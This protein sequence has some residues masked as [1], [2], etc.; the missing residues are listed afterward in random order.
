[1]FLPVSMS[2]KM[3]LVA[4]TSVSPFILRARDKREES[5]RSIARERGLKNRALHSFESRLK[6][7]TWDSSLIRLQSRQ[8]YGTTLSPLSRLPTFTNVTSFRKERERERE[9]MIPFI[10]D[11]HRWRA[12]REKS[13]LFIRFLQLV[14]CRFRL[15]LVNLFA[16]CVVLFA[17]SR[18]RSVCS[19][20]FLLH[21]IF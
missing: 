6:K 2:L 1:M 16:F 21:R 8:S 19:G 17:I 12:E 13:V 10:M 14:C 7:G 3:R 20:V 15:C 18:R 5:P 9:E 4:H 11:F